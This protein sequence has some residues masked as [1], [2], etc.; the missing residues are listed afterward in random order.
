MSDITRKLASI[1][2]I[3]NLKPINGADKIELAVI[4]GW[5][6]VVKKG[7]FSPG[8]PCVY[9]E[10]DS[11]LP[12]RPEFEFLRSSS[13]K[14]HP[15]LGQG[16]RL[17][18]IKLKGEFSQ[19]LAIPTDILNNFGEFISEH[20]TWS[21][22]SGVFPNEIDS[23][24]T[25]Y[26]GVKKWETPIPAQLAGQIRGLFP[27]FIPKTDQERV[28]NISFDKK[29]KIT[30]T[31]D[32][33]EFSKEYEDST[34]PYP[35]D[36]TFEVSL[37]LDGSSMTVYKK[38]SYVGVCSR[39]LDL[40]E[41]DSNAFWKCARESGLIKALEDDWFDN[42][43]AIQGE[44][45]GPGVQGNRENLEK[46]RFYVF[47]VYN[48]AA[49]QYFNPETA[50]RLIK[51]IFVDEFKVDIEYVPVYHPKYDGKKLNLEN[52]LKMA[53]GPS[54]TNKIREGV[55]FKANEGNY[56]FKAINNEF[57]LNEK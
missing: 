43:F 20:N 26:I 49:G 52:C 19:G 24:L 29:K 13:F 45:M 12:I 5:Q 15:E 33:K 3:D 32:G 27:S 21:N 10:I 23:D 55:V 44:L 48:I 36:F 16:F 39:N 7:D 4:G 9:F 53:S 14:E 56:S 35:Q 34:K 28:Q 25:N 18:T 8:D 42:D 22:D 51:E 54:L 57:L 30:W 50:A 37:K 6:V 41:T 2:K 1:R 46:L 11:F 17:K 31:I 47:S 38:G 40:T